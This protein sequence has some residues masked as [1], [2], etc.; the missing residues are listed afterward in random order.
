MWI[1]V[2]S[3]GEGGAVAQ[4][5]ALRSDDLTFPTYWQQGILIARGYHPH[6]F[7]WEY[8]LRPKRVADALRRPMET[9]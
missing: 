2:D 3:L 4:T 1:Y 8:F 6:A 9:S 5:M 7:E